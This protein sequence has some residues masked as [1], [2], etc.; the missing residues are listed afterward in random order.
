MPHTVALPIE[1]YL[2]FYVGVIR[3]LN[4][5]YQK[6]MTCRLVY[7][8]F[9]LSKTEFLI[10][11]YFTVLIHKDNRSKYYILICKVRLLRVL[12]ILFKEL[13]NI[14]FTL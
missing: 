4:N 13:I 1:L 3:T 2:P 10:N 6:F 5:K 11:K 14:N 7:N 9:F 8:I 12:N